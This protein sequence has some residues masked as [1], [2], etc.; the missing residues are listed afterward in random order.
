MPAEVNPITGW[1]WDGKLN[2]MAGF[3]GIRYSEL[4]R[5]IIE[6]GQARAAALTTATA[7][8]A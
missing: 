4:M 5:M 2:L 1:C 7:V 3:G 6:A 8:V